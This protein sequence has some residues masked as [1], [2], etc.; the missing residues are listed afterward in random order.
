M[1]DER[2][3]R[4]GPTGALQDEI[5]T[6]LIRMIRRTGLREDVLIRARQSQNTDWLSIERI[7]REH[8]QMES[9]AQRYSRPKAIQDPVHGAILLEPWE[10]DVISTW[11]MQ[12]L[13]YVRQLGPAYLVYPG[14]NHTRFEHSLGTNYLA[15]KCL[16]VVSYC[17]KLGAE[18]FHPLNRLLDDDQQM[19]FRAV[20]LLHDVGHPPTSHTI[21]PALGSWAGL[22]HIDLSEYL[23]L[24]SEIA[25][26]LSENGLSAIVVADVL[27]RRVSDPIL[28]LIS[29]F[30]D[31]PLDIDKTDY[32][33]RDARFSGAELG[34]FPAERVLLTSRVVRLDGAY[35]RAFMI[36]A[37]HSLEA[38]MLS[39]NWMF[40]D[41]YFH[42]TVR[43]AESLIDRATYLNLREEGLSRSEC[44]GL[45]TRMTDEDLYRWLA[46][47]DMA[48]VREYVNRI[49]HRRLFKVVVTRR[50]ESLS[51]ATRDRLLT[52]AR[53]VE[54]LMEIEK[55]LLDSSGGVIVDVVTPEVGAEKISQIPLIV[56]DA[57][58]RARVVRMTEIEAGRPLV[59]ILEQQRRTMP[60]VRLY[61]DATNAETVVRRFNKEFPS[62]TG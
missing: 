43:V 3:G 28:R 52:A 56:P 34:L 40:S 2:P 24:H 23:I 21:E 42:H 10:L 8:E 39:R 55:E 31:S 13:R 62:A 50:L 37:L 27:R 7:L 30:I 29:D 61:A 60:T 36:K 18:S 22:S 19:L 58:G 25:D 49:R 47:S 16:R 46:S 11:T 48:I 17:D 15:Q 33:I 45:F 51:D 14:A 1:S 5:D 35:V 12:R 4:E 20:A 59:S 53:D 41:L 9:L 26:V 54:R 6:D 44:I 57:V 38:L 32:L